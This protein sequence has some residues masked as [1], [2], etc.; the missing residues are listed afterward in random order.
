MPGTRAK[1]GGLAPTPDTD[2][3]TP[4]RANWPGPGT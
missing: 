1:G 2:P 4:A 3:G